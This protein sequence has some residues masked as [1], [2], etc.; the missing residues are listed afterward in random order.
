MR[1]TWDPQKAQLFDHHVNY[2]VIY[3]TDHST[4]EDRFI[5]IGPISRGLVTVVLV[6]VIDDVIHIVS[7]RRATR[8]EKLLFQRHTRGTN[9]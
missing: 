9:R 3:D 6:E 5:A 8:Q 1:T 7:A 4:D 2:L